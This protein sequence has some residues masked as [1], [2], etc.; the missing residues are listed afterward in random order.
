MGKN[1]I[2]PV[3]PSF[4]YT[5]QKLPKNIPKPSNVIPPPNIEPPTSYTQSPATY[6]PQPA[7]TIRPLTISSSFAVPN[8]AMY[9]PLPVHVG[10]I[11]KGQREYG[12]LVE[13]AI[14]ATDNSIGEL[15]FKNGANAKQFIREA[16]EYLSQL[17]Y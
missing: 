15:M 5:Q 12:M 4:T 11:K 16:L 1:S 8:Q 14:K 6:I 7:S 13:K 9:P 3:N 17:E 2:P 10:R